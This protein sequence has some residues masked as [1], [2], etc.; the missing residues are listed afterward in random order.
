M[1]RGER[2]VGRN[3]DDRV[4]PQ[5]RLQKCVSVVSETL[6]GLLTSW[7]CSH[8]SLFHSTPHFPLFLSPPTPVL[9]QLGW[10][11]RAC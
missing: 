5:E 11:R 7:R 3:W 2:I 1:D 9:S 4:G 10:Q 8:R 6:H